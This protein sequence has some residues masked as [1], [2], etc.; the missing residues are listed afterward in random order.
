MWLQEFSHSQD[1][2]PLLVGHGAESY[3]SS[4]I[5]YPEQHYLL[6]T[7]DVGLRVE[8]E[9]KWKDEWRQ[10][11]TIASDNPKHHDDVDWVFGFHQSEYKSITRLTPKD[12]EIFL[13]GFHREYQAVQHAVFKFLEEWIS[14]LTVTNWH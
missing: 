4:Q 9:V 2:V 11:V 1:W 12:T 8:C 3:S 7:L 10:N 5:L 6:Q 14:S 13:L